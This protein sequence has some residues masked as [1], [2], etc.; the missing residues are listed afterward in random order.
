MSMSTT[1][2]AASTVRTVVDFDIPRGACD[3]HVHVFD[4]AHFPY[5]SER[6]Y[7][8]PEASIDDLRNL[9]TALHFDRAVVVAPS[10]YGTDNSCTIDAVRQLGARARGVVV[11][12]KSITA[13]ALDD[14]AAV[15]VRGV[16][17]N[18]ESAGDTDAVAAK[19]ALN[20]IAEQLRG[21]DWHI[22][23]DT[24]LSVITALKDD[25]AAL[26]FPVIFSHFGRAR[27]ALGPSQPGFDDLLAL[28]KSGRVYVKISAPYRT[29]DKS[30]DFPDAAPLAQALV[31][32]NADRVV[33]GSNWPHPGRSPTPSAIARP[34]PN[35]DG[36]VL[37]LLPKWVPD[38]AIRKKILVDNPA[39]LYGF[40]AAA[41]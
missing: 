21:R 9:Q 24:R 35:D 28:V 36:H 26:P 34:Y 5:D 20:A 1:I 30:P 17:L 2:G 14:M 7:T 38:S 41:L 18:L 39:Q 3:C 25:I 23:F 32:A 33:W 8:P 40:E 29:S 4:P 31:A 22:Q 27:A 12:D 10:V 37:N 11:I 19:K 16:R 15:G 6:I 13:A